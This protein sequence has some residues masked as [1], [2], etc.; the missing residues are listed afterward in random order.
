M[1]RRLYHPD[2]IP[3][4]IA[5]GRKQHE[6]LGFEFPYSPQ[7][8]HTLLK[9]SMMP[10]SPDKAV[11]GAYDKNKVVGVLIAGIEPFAFMQGEYVCDMIF[12]AEKHGEKLYRA[13]VQWG[14][15]HGAVAVQLAVT[16]GVPQAEKFYEKQGLKRIG[17]VYLKAFGGEQCQQ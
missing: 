9:A 4:L 1:I 5:F 6:R 2:S 10:H 15:S 8:C 16:T 11:W 17:G 12:V 13:M 3:K 14:Q 7:K